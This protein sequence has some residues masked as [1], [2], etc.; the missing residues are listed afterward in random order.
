MLLVHQFCSYL[1][2]LTVEL[3]PTPLGAFNASGIQGLTLKK[4]VLIESSVT[5]SRT[6]RSGQVRRLPD[7][8]ARVLHELL[9][10]DLL[11]MLLICAAHSG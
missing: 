5:R 6:A 9:V 2:N 1:R 11:S 7:R 8:D 4:S 3:D 10:R